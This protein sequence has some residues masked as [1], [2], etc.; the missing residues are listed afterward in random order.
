MRDPEQAAA[1]VDSFADTYPELKKHLIDERDV[2]MADALRH[3]PG[4]RIVAVIGAGH[5]PGISAILH[6]WREN[7]HPERMEHP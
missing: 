5:V 2:Y 7:N 4:T 3:A 6:R 1:L